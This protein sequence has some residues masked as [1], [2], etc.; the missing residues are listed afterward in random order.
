MLT[1]HAV[2][3]AA[4]HSPKGPHARSSSDVER[5]FCICGVMTAL[6][7][8]CYRSLHALRRQVTHGRQ[9]ER[10][11][12]SRHARA[13]LRDGAESRQ[14]NGHRASER[15]ACQALHRRLSRPKNHHGLELRFP[16]KWDGG[17][18]GG[19]SPSLMVR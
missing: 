7:P 2:F 10:H 12:P 15:A 17:M 1:V 8:V 16:I 18:D 6:F 9:Y 14:Q 4:R 5:V 19:T 13:R 11:C 3:D